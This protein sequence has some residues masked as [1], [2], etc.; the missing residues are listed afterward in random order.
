MD[1][2]L[3]ER[4][5]LD[6]AGFGPR[7]GEAGAL[8]EQG[9]EAWVRAQL[10]RVSPGDAGLEERLAP[11]PS[12]RETT[13]QAGV[14][15]EV[16]EPEMQDRRSAERRK[17]LKKRSREILREL[18]GARLVRA[19]HGRWGLRE[20]LLDFWSNHFSVYGRKSLVGA[21]LPHYENEVLLPHVLGRFED[22]LLA[23]ARSPAM[24]VYLDNWTST[25]P[26]APRFVR[27]RLR[28]GGGINENYARELLELH[29]LGVEGGY[30]QEDVVEVA[31]VFTGWSLESRRNPE[32]RFRSLLHDAG[33]KRVLGQRV[34][35]E[36]IEE[37]ENLLRL[38]ARHPAT[39]HHLARKLCA[40]FV[41]DDPRPALVERAA[42]RYLETEGDLREVVA[43]VL[44]APELAA[45]GS[46]KLKTPFRMLASALRTTGGECDGRRASLLALVRLGEV[47]YGSR[48]P[49]GFPEAASHWVDPGAMLE[50]MAVAFQLAEGRVR[51]A[52]LG[53][54]LPATVAPL[55]ALEGSSFAERQ[56]L[57]LASPEFQWA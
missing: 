14:A 26:D 25:R 22:L 10:A 38:L 19:V 33:A 24:L 29:T 52:R 55:S 32:F 13:W 5:L 50:R 56:A 3:R 11:F 53:P 30:S 15:M 4:R 21:L 17:E 9:A 37:G 43:T 28:G 45:P 16:P 20:A 2:N 23:V 44:L 51:G 49:D 47:P 57:A 41:A 35:G 7:P 39:A 31:R 1:R 8:R 27:R 36:G 6:R 18:A 34:R 40:R 46:R 48:T 54:E 42:R 12:L